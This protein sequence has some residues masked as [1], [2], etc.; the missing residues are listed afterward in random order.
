MPDMNNIVSNKR[1]SEIEKT[2]QSPISYL[3]A[4]LY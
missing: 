3:K 4:F 1:I 2:K